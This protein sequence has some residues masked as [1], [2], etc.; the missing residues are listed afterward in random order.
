M[1]VCENGVGKIAGIKPI[2]DCG[3][4]RTIVA[5]LAKRLKADVDYDDQ[6]NGLESHRN[7]GIWGGSGGPPVP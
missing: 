7:G 3:F 5:A 1:K 2:A 6:L 4:G